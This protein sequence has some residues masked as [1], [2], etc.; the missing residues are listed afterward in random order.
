MAGLLERMGV[1][2][3]SD[4]AALAI[5]CLAFS[6]WHAAREQVEKLGLVISTSLGGVKPNPAVTIAAAAEAQM[7]KLL[8]EF[9]CT[10]SSRGRLRVG[11][12]KPK[13]KLAAFLGGAKRKA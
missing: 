13:S 9:G 5:Y 1:I 8:A 10:P 11:G 3:Q 2:A 6:R 12:E 7:T 4:G